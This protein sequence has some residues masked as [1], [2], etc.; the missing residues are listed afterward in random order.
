MGIA[1][2]WGDINIL[3]SLVPIGGIMKYRIVTGETTK[4][5]EENVQ[6]ALDDGWELS[7]EVF[8]WRPHGRDYHS[9]NQPMIKVD[10]AEELAKF[11]IASRF[12]EIDES[13]FED[14][15]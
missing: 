14:G 7:G 6:E 8:L 15:E 9:L 12:A 13:I 2:I 5:F 1:Y 3:A 10:I 11:G 4:T